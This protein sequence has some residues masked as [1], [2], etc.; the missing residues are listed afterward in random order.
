M[1]IVSA[2]PELY[3]GVA[4]ERLGADAVIATRLAVDDRQLL[5]GRYEGLNCRGEEKIQRLRRWIE[6]SGDP[7]ARVWAYGNSRG[8][9]K[10][11]GAA[12]IGVDVG[13]LGRL[14]RL[15]A[16]PR[17]DATGPGPDRP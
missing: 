6:Q 17:L 8:D 4:A 13:R 11:L 3:V 2:S 5:T 16:F 14:G 7:P 15:H 12:D 1:V 9:L 10:M